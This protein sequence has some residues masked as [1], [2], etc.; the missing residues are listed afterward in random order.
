M[1]KLF[2]S[3]D[4]GQ[5]VQY[6]SNVWRIT[7]I[8]SANTAVIANE[9]TQEIKS[10]TIDSLVLISEPGKAKTHPIAK[11]VADLSEFSDENWAQAQKRYDIIK[12]LIE[13]PSRTKAL[14]EQVAV[15]SGV[16]YGTIY[17]WMSKYLASRSMVSLVDEKRGPRKGDTK[18]VQEIEVVIT[19][20][21]EELYL[22]KQRMSMK[23]LAKEIRR[24]C[25]NAGL[26]PPHGNSIRTRI[27]E[28]PEALALRRRGM[29]EQ[30][31]ALKP[32][33][34]NFPGADYPLSIVQIDH[35][36]ADIIVVDEQ[37]RLPLGRPW[38][39][40]AIDV[41]SRMLVGIYVTMEKPSE[42]STGLCL[43]MGMLQKTMYLAEL[44]VEGDWPV[45]GKIE[46]VHADNGKDFKGAMLQR[47]CET[48][49]IDLHFRPVR[50]PHYGGHIERMMGTV[51]NAI[52]AM[53]GTTFSNT[54]DRKGYH[55]ENNSALTLKE[56]ERLLVDF[57]VNVYHKRVHS[58]LLMSPLQRW[59]QGIFGD[60]TMPGTGIPTVV[61][62]PQRMVID[63]LP[64]ETRTVQPYGV[65][66][67]ELQYFSNGM[68]RWIDVADPDH[69]KLK[70]K[71]TVRR[72]PR[73][74]S[75]VYFFD[76]DLNDYI[77]VPT[78]SLAL[79]PVSLWE[80]REVRRRLVEEG[81]KSVNEH[82]IAEALHRMRMSAQDAVIKTKAARRAVARHKATNLA[83]KVS[84]SPKKLALTAEPALEPKEQPHTRVQQ[85]KS[86][87]SAL[88]GDIFSKPIEPFGDIE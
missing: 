64:F 4:V 84:A 44:G 45:W 83:S 57:I 88:D 31:N 24:R 27:K 63:F 62:D 61:G 9:V 50:V 2:K 65:Q 39:T 38:I 73:D 86:A 78:R 6:E 14:V 19:Q 3:I 25:K 40:L 79:P 53:P 30:A 34:G 32:L 42:I 33:R 80:Y 72:D 11:R 29:R 15:A 49:G 77:V 69:L 75:K 23:D 10:C 68:A 81:R 52:H 20:T 67:D 47:A 21:V 35:T 56:F 16:H 1:T 82:E 43:S 36:E 5:R 8:T 76:P 18:L 60:G 26:T 85:P 13:A 55:S 7:H 51:S 87:P 17:K 22:H 12:P 70:R 46:V 48:Y 58:E 54:Q 71:F 28:I 41:C 66:I 37:H 59:E 74:I